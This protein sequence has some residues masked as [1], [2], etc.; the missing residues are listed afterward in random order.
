MY[1]EPKE[2]FAL[3]IGEISTYISVPY[4][5]V[6]LI[7][8]YTVEKI[9]ESEPRSWYNNGNEWEKEFLSQPCPQEGWIDS[10]KYWNAI[11]DIINLEINTNER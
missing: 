7:L 3:M 4:M 6:L 9:L 1:K 11:L 10:Q 2:Q 5:G 8:K